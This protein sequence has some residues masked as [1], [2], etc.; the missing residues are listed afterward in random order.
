VN[1]SFVTIVQFVFVGV[2][3][4]WELL[5]LSL[6]EEACFCGVL[7]HVELVG[8]DESALLNKH[9]TTLDP[10]P[11]NSLLAEFLATASVSDVKLLAALSACGNLLVP[12]PRKKKSHNIS[13]RATSNVINM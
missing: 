12:D 10:L 7:K 13:L 8:T 5:D 6:P 2:T 9:F 11:I 4:F 3:S 1:L